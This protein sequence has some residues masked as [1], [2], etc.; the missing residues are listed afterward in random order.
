MH[1][2]VLENRQIILDIVASY[3][4]SNVRVFGS[5]ARGD[6]TDESDIDLLVEFPPEGMGLELF[7]MQQRIEEALGR[8]VDI[9]REHALR[10]AVPLSQTNHTIQEA[11]R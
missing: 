11:G 7:E 1:P 9:G 8:K 2:F 3:G 6:A 4:C 5:M 10:Y